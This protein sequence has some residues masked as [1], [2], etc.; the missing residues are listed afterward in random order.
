MNS[1]KLLL[2][3]G[4][5]LNHRPEYLCPVEEDPLFHATLQN[6]PEMVSVLL[7]HKADISRKIYGTTS[8]DLARILDL[9]DVC[10]ILKNELERKH[11]L[12]KSELQTDSSPFMTILTLAGVNKKEFISKLVLKG[13]DINDTAGHGFNPLHESIN[14]EDEAMV[15]H[16]LQCGA[17]PNRQS[18]EPGYMTPLHIAIIKG[19]LILVKML[20][21]LN[22]KM[23]VVRPVLVL[24]GSD[25]YYTDWIADPK[26]MPRHRSSLC[27][28]VCRNFVTI[29]HFLL[30]AGN[31]IAE[32]DP[33]SVKF[34]IKHTK[35]ESIRRQ[36][37]DH[38][39]TPRSLGVLCRNYLRRMRRHD[40]QEFVEKQEL[41]HSLKQSLLLQDSI[42]PSLFVKRDNKYVTC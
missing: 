2:K 38:M 27:D 17:D 12:V 42:E 7:D 20:L 21:S 10:V 8:Y 23:E 16:L 24:W 3:H 22:V 32:E 29:A 11:L 6:N 26:I 1:L 15:K 40:I 25:T 37:I 39:Q 13:L 35:S 19:N 33:E 4:F 31:D 30:E 34:I 9:K 5:Q 28:A 36:L 18:A 14:R 41:P